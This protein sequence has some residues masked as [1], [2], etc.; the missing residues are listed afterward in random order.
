MTSRPASS[1]PKGCSRLGDSSLFSILICP[2]CASSGRTG[3]SKPS[4]IQATRTPSPNKAT[5]LC[6]KVLIASP[7]GVRRL[8]VD[9]GSATPVIGIALVVDTAI[10]SAGPDSRVKEAVQNVDD[11]V[12]EDIC[13]GNEQRDSKQARV[14]QF[15]RHL[16]GELTDTRPREDRFG[17]HRAREQTGKGQAND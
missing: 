16:D 8:T 5:G 1:V 15:Q 2:F 6:R 14:V 13:D 17:E 4:R 10:S 3:A 11:Q 9:S 12:D 7:A